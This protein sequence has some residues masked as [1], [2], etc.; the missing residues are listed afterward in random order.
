MYF[1]PRAMFLLGRV[2]G[3]APNAGGMHPSPTIN[4]ATATNVRFIARFLLWTPRLQWQAK[5][6]PIHPGSSRQSRH[7]TYEDFNMKERIRNLTG[8]LG[9]L[10]YVFSEFDSQRCQVEAVRPTNKS[11]R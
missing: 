2:V 6:T 3:A 11:G 10:A 4:V 8:V 9:F 5:G 1:A 7:L